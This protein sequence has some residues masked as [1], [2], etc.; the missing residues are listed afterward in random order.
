M[1]IADIFDSA[2]ENIEAKAFE[3]AVYT[4]HTTLVTA[5]V[6]I[7]FNMVRKMEIDGSDIQVL[8]AS[9]MIEMPRGSLT[10]MPEKG[11]TI[12]RSHDS[13]IYTV[14]AN[15]TGDPHFITVS[16]V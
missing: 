9:I 14:I 6:K 13:A 11:D 5:A 12:T 16:V 1:S 2:A 4:Y 10:R 8:Q 15:E 3:D 7:N